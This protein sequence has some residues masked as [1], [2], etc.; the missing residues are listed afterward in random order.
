MKVQYIYA[1]RLLEKRHEREI[2][3]LVHAQGV[4]R[5]ERE[6]KGRAKVAVFERGVENLRR[7]L[8]DASDAAKVWNRFH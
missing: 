3:V 7:Q 8:D 2:R 6:A 1:Q 5:T 4:R